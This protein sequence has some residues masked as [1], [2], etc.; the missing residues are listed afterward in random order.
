MTFL[1]D[2][3]VLYILHQPLHADYE[4][5]HRW[6][7]GRRSDPFATCAVTQTG[8]LR[9]LMQE[10]GG[11]DRFPLDDARRAL[12]KLTEHPRHIF[13]PEAPPYIDT[14]GLPSKRIQGHR[15]IADAYLLGLAIRNKGTLATLDAGIRHLAGAEFSTHVELIQ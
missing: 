4:L 9:L 8:M 10:I 6:F 15:Q 3:N 2:V 7:S 14:A 5:V 12:K 11:L 13:W 1:L